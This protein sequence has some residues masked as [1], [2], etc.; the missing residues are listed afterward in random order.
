VG[1][2]VDGFYAGLRNPH[3]VA[4]SYDEFFQTL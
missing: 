3:K 2:G 1:Y 4:C